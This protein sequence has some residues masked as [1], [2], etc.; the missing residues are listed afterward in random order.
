MKLFFAFTL[1][2]VTA[3]GSG[4]YG[5]K[6][7]TL[8]ANVLAK[9]TDS[10]RSQWQAL[11]QSI[12][13]LAAHFPIVGTNT[14]AGLKS[15]KYY[16]K[17]LR[18]CEDLTQTG[19]GYQ[20]PKN[21]LVLYQGDESPNYDTYGIE[22]ALAEPDTSL[23][24]IDLMKTTSDTNGAGVDKLKEP[25]TVD[26]T[27]VRRYNYGMIDFYTP[28]KIKAE[29]TMNGGTTYYTRK[30]TSFTPNTSSP[31]EA[32]TA[33]VDD[34]T[35]SP[36]EEATYQMTNGGAY[37]LF[38]KPFEITDADV[39]N[40][41]NVKIDLVFNPDNFARASDLD[42]AGP[43]ILDAS[44]RAISPPFVR[45]NP[46]P[47]KSGDT[48]RKE[49]YLITMD[50]TSSTAHKARVELYYNS[51][52][53]SKTIYGVDSAIVYESTATTSVNS[54][55]AL[56]Y[57]VEVDGSVS[58]LD[59]QKSPTLKEL[60]RRESGTL[61]IVCLYTGSICTTQGA[62]VS[63]SYTYVGDYLVSAD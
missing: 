13:P 26:S 4:I 43:P 39:T 16:I 38:Q 46:V 55:I 20:N 61:K 60:K 24:Y 15:L 29:F 3:C 22:T 53:S 41:T 27:A 51:S 56:N 59:Y 33:K 54:I 36:A 17:T 8:T 28:I 18:I 49:V 2:F 25:F 30:T 32:H 57:A 35:Q 11:R 6:G 52:D 63:R 48:T 40:Q 14:A 12:P 7:G 31:F 62:E 37:F 19:S 42:T 58:L 1:F 5:K 50:T 45:M 34:L 47:R 23:R 10:A 44:N 9:G 21:C